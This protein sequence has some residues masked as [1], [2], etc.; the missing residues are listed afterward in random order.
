M[1]LARAL[2]VEPKVLLLDESFGALD[3]RVREELR[4]WLRRMPG[5]GHVT[6]VVVTHDQ[7][8]AMEVASRI[9]VMNHAKVEQVGSLAELDEEPAN[10]S[11]MGVVGKVDRLRDASSRPHEVAICRP[12]DPGCRPATVERRLGLGFETR[13]ELRLQ[14]DGQRLWARLTGDE[15]ARLTLAP[16]ETVGV[17]LSRGRRLNGLTAGEV[18][19]AS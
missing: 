11:V 14:E 2:A 17:D 13:V 15:A 7:E 10:D 4:D 3:A 1:A 6:M 8:E 18:R 16:R 19:R 12:G 5:E 9:V